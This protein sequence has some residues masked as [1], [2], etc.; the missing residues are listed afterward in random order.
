[1]NQ[2]VFHENLYIYQTPV[3][4]LWFIELPKGPLIS[5]GIFG[6]LNSSKKRTKEFDLT[7]S[8]RIVFVFLDKLKTQKRHFEIN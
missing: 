8:G 3:I 5:K 1:M 6:T 4:P 2:V 7:T